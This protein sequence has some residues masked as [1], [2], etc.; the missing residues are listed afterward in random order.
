MNFIY[1]TDADG[2]LVNTIPETAI[3]NILLRLTRD[4]STE[5]ISSWYSL[6]DGTTWLFV[7]D[8]VLPEPYTNPRLGIVAGNSS[9]EFPLAEIS[10]AEI[11]THHIS[12]TDALSVHPGSLVFKA[13]EGHPLGDQR[14]IHIST[15]IGRQVTWSQTTDVPWLT[16]DQ[17][18]GFAEATLRIGVNT[19]GLT[20]GIHQGNLTLTSTQAGTE[21]LIVPVT[22]IVNPDIPV[23]A[24]TWRDGRNGAMSVSVDDGYDSGSSE[25]IENGLQGTYVCNGTTPPSYYSYLYEHGM[26]LGAHTTNH[27]YGFIPPND[28]LRDVEFVP[29]INGICTQTPQPCSDVITLVWP[30]GLCNYRSQA[31]ASEYFLS[32]R[33]Y[34]INQL[35]DATPENF[36]NLKSF[37][38]HNDILLPP[39]TDFITQVNLAIAQRRWFNL[40]LH[41]LTDDDGAIDYAS[42]QNIWVTSIGN[43]I[44][45]ILQRDRLILSNYSVGPHNLS[46]TASRLPI[47]ASPV[48]SFEEAFGPDDITTLQIDIDDSRTIESVLVN[49]TVNPYQRIEIDGNFVLLTNVLLEP[50]VAKT[51]EIRYYDESLPR[52]HLSSDNLSFATLLGANPGNQIINITSSNIAELI[53]TVSSDATLPDW[54]SVTPYSGTGNGTLTVTVDRSGLVDGNYHKTITVTAENVVNSPQIVDV[55]FTVRTPILA[56]SPPNIS[57]FATTNDPSPSSQIINVS[58]SGT[59]EVITWNSISNVPWISLGSESGST[60]GTVEVTIDHTGLIA[61]TYNGIV[62]ISSDVASNSPSLVNVRLTVNEQGVFHY[63]F[64]YTDRNSLLADGWDYIARTP[65]GGVRNTEQTAGAVVSFD[66]LAHPGVIRIPVDYGSLYAWNN[67]SRNSLFRD[68]PGNWTSIRLF[69]AAFAPTQSSQLAGLVLYQDDNTYLQLNRLFS[70]GGYQRVNF[71]YEAEAN[72]VVLNSI[73]ESTTNNLLLRID[74]EPS[75]E[76]VS[77]W[78]SLDNGISWVFVGSVVLPQPL[79]NPRLGIVTGESSGGF[80]EADISWAEIQTTAEVVNKKLALENIHGPLSSGIILHQNYPNPFSDYTW[81]EYD[82]DE[83]SHIQMDLYNISGKKLETIIDEYMMA[84]RYKILWQSRDY[85]PGIYYLILKNT[86]G[87][88]RIM[89][90]KAK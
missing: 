7:G 19:S 81:I 72:G 82:L 58:N 25:L 49:G 73:S 12:I 2:L 75:T 23:Q 4:P 76:T 18:G 38:S 5:T 87:S 36:M 33:G 35:E 66:Q 84:G 8:A 11:G 69:I 1:E 61:G 27:V 47:P 68:L 16:T 77:S 64:T 90:I 79:T 30:N 60:P 14:S 55:F 78:Y 6:D 46:F 15:I 85:V 52:M 56:V 48:R 39:P 26:E 70:A 17:P 62:T 74:R 54:L 22:L 31:L 42:T 24:T 21:P 67:D 59:S 34:H 80:P 41:N 86:I 45:Y 28:I 53:W 29:N 3:S 65:F 9:E 83:D 43:V 71:I 51:I 32:A 88:E 40:V 10:W 44:K 37:N 50:S 13:T 20:A 63:D 89:L 57:F